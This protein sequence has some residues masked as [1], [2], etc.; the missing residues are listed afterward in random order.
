[1]N[2]WKYGNVL[3]GVLR[4]AHRT[5]T[6]AFSYSHNSIF[7]RFHI[8]TLAKALAVSLFAYF[9]LSTFAYSGEVAW[10]DE[11]IA[12]AG[13]TGEWSQDVLYERATGRAAMDG[14]YVF[15]PNA[16]S[17]GNYVTLKVAASFPVTMGSAGP[18][19]DAQAAVKMGANG[20]Q[21]W[22]GGSQ[23]IATGGAGGTQFIATAPM[24]TT[25][26]TMG[27]DAIN[28]VPPAWVDVSAHGVTP[29]AGREYELEFVFDDAARRYSVAVKD[30]AGAWRR[31]SDARGRQAFALAA[32]AERISSITLDGRTRF[33]SLKGSHT[34]A[35]LS[36]AEARRRGADAGPIGNAAALAS[37]SQTCLEFRRGQSNS[38][39]AYLEFRRRKSNSPQACLEFRRTKSNSPQGPPEFGWTQSNSP[40][41][42]S[43]SGWAQS[44]ETSPRN[45]I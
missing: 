17:A 18:G 15:T 39:Q 36:R 24:T 27:M 34:D 31:L 10:I 32:K 41:A 33:R 1:M 2:I 42:P 22:A 8:S 29:V 37:T 21:I 26:G 19:A 20:F 9:H 11:S 6:E 35:V 4:S 45:T 38:P 40:Q 7:S 16:P 25:H 28:C 14:E 5:S 23:F 12:T 43:E 30:D 44:K 13:D 3:R